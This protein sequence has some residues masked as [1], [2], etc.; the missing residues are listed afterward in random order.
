[1]LALPGPANNALGYKYML[2]VYYSTAVG[3]LAGVSVVF[4]G[5]IAKNVTSIT[6]V[7]ASLV[8]LLLFHRGLVVAC[9]ESPNF[10]LTFVLD[11]GCKG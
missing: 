2:S 10:V 9:S 11:N 5:N 1:M 4:R 3:C 6:E 8:F 7:T